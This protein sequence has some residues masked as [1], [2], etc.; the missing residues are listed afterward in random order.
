MTRA[1]G[2]W[3]PK[4][5]PKK[6]S[7][8]DGFEVLAFVETR[9]SRYSNEHGTTSRW[10]TCHLGRQ[11]PNRPVLLSSHTYSTHHIYQNDSYRRV[12]KWAVVN[13]VLNQ[14]WWHMIHIMIYFIQRNSP[15]LQKLWHLKTAIFPSINQVVPC[16]F[17]M[18]NHSCSTNTPPKTLQTW[19]LH[20]YPWIRDSYLSPLTLVPRHEAKLIKFIKVDLPLGGLLDVPVPTCPYEK[21][22]YKPYKKWV[23]YRL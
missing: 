14:L 12:M 16:W 22:L 18:N 23:C 17:N 5:K 20:E 4:R 3:N 21:S 7:T 15:S 10:N 2:R 11:H 9:L 19:G 1:L 8:D 13:L 6:D